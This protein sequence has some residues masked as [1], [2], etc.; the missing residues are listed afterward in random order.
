MLLLCHCELNNDINLCFVE[1][2]FVINKTHGIFSENLLHLYE[3]CEVRKE[4]G[5]NK[6][7]ETLFLKLKYHVKVTL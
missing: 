6:W 1:F 4:R 3:L 7:H 5:K 2:N